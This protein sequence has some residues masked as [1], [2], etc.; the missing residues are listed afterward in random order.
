MKK[1]MDLNKIDKNKFI[2]D[3]NADIEYYQNE[4]DNLK[5]TM[6]N[7]Y[8]YTTDKVDKLSF[9]SDSNKIIYYSVKIEVLK[10]F[11]SELESGITSLRYM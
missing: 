10:E 4:L 6:L 7:K 2:N 3:I 8:L 9:L 1:T 5:K 11:K